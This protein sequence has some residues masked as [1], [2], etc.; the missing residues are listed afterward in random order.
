MTFCAAQI[1]G[2]DGHVTGLDID[3]GVLTIARAAV[4]DAGITN[5]SFE[6][7]PI[8]EHAPQQAYDA[9]IGRHILI[10]TPEP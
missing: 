4:A 1:V 8:T 10:H 3:A 6:Q 2:P 7:Q 9:V 5:V